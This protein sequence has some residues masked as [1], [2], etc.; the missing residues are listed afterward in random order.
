MPRSRN[1]LENLFRRNAYNFYPALL[2]PIVADHI[3]LGPL[4]HIMRNAI[5]FD[6]DLCGGTIKID[7]VFSD[8]MLSTKLHAHR[9]LAQISPEQHFGQRHFGA[10]CAGFGV[11]VV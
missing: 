9:L 11:V 5:D 10:E 7:H 4:T 3:A 6:P 8:W 2:E 1:R